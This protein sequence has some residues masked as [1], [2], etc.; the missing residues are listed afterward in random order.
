MPG[1]GSPL[2]F[3]IATAA[4]A[5]AEYLIFRY[6]TSEGKFKV[7]KEEKAKIN[8]DIQKILKMDSPM[9]KIRGVREILVPDIRDES[10]KTMVDFVYGQM[11]EEY[12]RHPELYLKL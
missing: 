12:S 6:M 5:A 7:S 1:E 2:A 9:K 10:V 8:E 11:E 4:S 3:G